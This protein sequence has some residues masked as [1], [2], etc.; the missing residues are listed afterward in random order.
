[1]PSTYST[2]LKLEL[3]ATGEASGVWGTNTNNNLGTLIEQ[4]IVGVG[5]VAM[6]DSN[7]TIS[8]ADGVTST[9]RMVYIVCTGALSASRNLV[10]PTIDKNYIIENATTGGY[11]IVVKTTAGT[12]I[13]VGAGLKRFVYVNSTNVIEAINS[14]GDLSVTGDLDVTGTTTFN[15]SLILGTPLPVASGGTGVA[16]STGTTAVV[17]ST[18]PTLVTPTLGVATATSINKVAIT[19]PATS[20]TLTLIDGTTLT[21]P[22]ASGTAATLAGTET[23]TNK[24]LTAPTINTGAMGAASTA[25]TQT[26]GDNST[27]LATTAYV[28]KQVGQIVSSITGAV[29]TGTTVFPI[30]DTIPQNTEGDEYLSLAITP[31]SATSTLN[32]QVV[33]NVAGDGTTM[34]AAIFQDSTA[35]ALAVGYVTPVAVNTTNQ[36]VINYAMTSGTASATTFKVRAGLATGS[37][38]TFNGT[39]GNR[40]FGGALAS[41]II[42]TE[43]L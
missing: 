24:T 23:L 13:T 9:A 17:L 14:I 19:A 37:P 33:L 42:I 16:L 38:L 4:A 39:S 15:G 29:D 22:A 27:K 10:V 12:G 26:A 1:M 7:Q 40:F 34:A 36:I 43:T 31:K 5:T 20:A 18:S 35:N 2:N 8:I 32:I 25:T 11:S 28:D 30:D 21:G 6:A 41:G 3:M